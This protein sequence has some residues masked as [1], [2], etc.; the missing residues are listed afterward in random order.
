MIIKSINNENS[1]ASFACGLVKRLACW[2]RRFHV[3]LLSRA[4]DHKKQTT[5]GDEYSVVMEGE[6]FHQILATW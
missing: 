6:F 3:L 5:E 1:D 4:L 2:F